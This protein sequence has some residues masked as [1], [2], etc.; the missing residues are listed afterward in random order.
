[1]MKKKIR[2]KKIR[3]NLKFENLFYFVSSQVINQVGVV[4]VACHVRKGL[5]K[6]SSSTRSFVTT[7]GWDES[8]FPLFLRV[9][10][11]LFNSPEFPS[12]PTRSRQP[13]SSSR[14]TARTQ[15]LESSRAAE[16]RF[17]GLSRWSKSVRWCQR[18]AR[19]ALPSTEGAAGCTSRWGFSARGLCC[20]WTSDRRWADPACLS[21]PLNQR[22]RAP[23]RGRE[24]P[25]WLC[26]TRDRRRWSPVGSSLLLLRMRGKK[27]LKE[28]F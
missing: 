11:C 8:F 1:M 5:T 17:S 9:I 24:S 7:H 20:S 27:A 16:S 26:S 6:F 4:G 13:N 23:A 14:C 18:R 28:I 22:K 12:V 3:K 2:N 21:S 10:S 25:A 15:L 19:K